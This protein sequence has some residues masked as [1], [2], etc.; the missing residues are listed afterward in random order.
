MD[1]LED[2][3]LVGG[4]QPEG[5]QLNVKMEIS[6]EWCPLGGPY[7]DQGCLISSLTT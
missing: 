5:Q 4:S 6:D 7:W 1:S 3:E 2:E